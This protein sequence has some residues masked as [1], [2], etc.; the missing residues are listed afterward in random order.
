MQNRNYYNCQNSYYASNCFLPFVCRLGIKID[1][2]EFNVLYTNSVRCVF[3]N[4]K[5]TY[6]CMQ[7]SVFNVVLITFY[8]YKGIRFLILK[9]YIS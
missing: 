5:N 8:S 9:N 6:P 1:L 7:E 3:V 2:D 4:C